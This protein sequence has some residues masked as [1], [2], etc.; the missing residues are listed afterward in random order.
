MEQKPFPEEK[1]KGKEGDKHRTPSR[2]QEEPA[3]HEGA[4]IFSSKNSEPHSAQE[5][6]GE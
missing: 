1:K 6:F 4:M 3:K 2:N 5:L